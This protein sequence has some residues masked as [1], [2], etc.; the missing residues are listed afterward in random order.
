MS[1]ATA[2]K[3]DDK[4]IIGQTDD[5]NDDPSAAQKSNI[6]EWLVKMNEVCLSVK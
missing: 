5:E 2:R 1:H 4:D 3:H 6:T